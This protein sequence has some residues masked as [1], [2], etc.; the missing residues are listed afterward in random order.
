[1]A[2]SP[3]LGSWQEDGAFAASRFGWLKPFDA[4]I[5]LV[6]DPERFS[7]TIKEPF[8]APDDGAPCRESVLKDEEKSSVAPKGGCGLAWTPEDEEKFGAASVEE[9]LDGGKFP[10]N[11]GLLAPGRFPKGR[12]GSVVGPMDG[13]PRGGTIPKGGFTRDEDLARTG[14]DC[15]RP[16]CVSV[17]GG[18]ERK[19]VEGD[20]FL[21]APV[22]PAKLLMIVFKANL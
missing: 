18:G 16:N 15:R 22:F 1:M 6:L 17:S 10:E 14:L 4:L 7:A 20:D 12:R 5:G 8:S 13:P 11:E 2:P 19:G 3:R 9:E 21:F